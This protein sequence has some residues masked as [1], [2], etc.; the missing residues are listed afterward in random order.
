MPVHVYPDNGTY[1][2]TLTV[3]DGHGGSNVATTT[4]TIGNVAPQVNAGTASSLQSGQTLS[5]SGDVTDAGAA[6]TPS[7]WRI[8]WG[9][10]TTP[11]SG[12]SAVPGSVSAAH[13]YYGTGTFTLQLTV[14]DKDGG[15]G[16]GVVRSPSTPVP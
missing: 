14:T 6:D 12:T 1:T 3:D 8:D 7:S 2:I 5:F 11:L 4:A 10:G 9:D 15:V 13:T 16:T